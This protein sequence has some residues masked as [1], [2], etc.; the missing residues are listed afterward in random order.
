MG[1]QYPQH[2]KD[3]PPPDMIPSKDFCIGQSVSCN[4][5]ELL[6]LFDSEGRIMDI[7][8]DL[9]TVKFFTKIIKIHKR[10]LTAR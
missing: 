2:Q 4:V 8:G 5:W 10:G 1:L 6:S 3:F 9:C 7:E